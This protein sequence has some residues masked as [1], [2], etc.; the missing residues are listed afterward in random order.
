MNFEA[1]RSRPEPIDIEV[2]GEKVRIAEQNDGSFKIYIKNCSFRAEQIA[3]EIKIED[4]TPHEFPGAWQADKLKPLAL[5]A[6]SQIH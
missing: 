2:D 1:P 4:I 3:D 6:L 5:K